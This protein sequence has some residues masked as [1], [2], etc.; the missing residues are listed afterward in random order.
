MSWLPAAGEPASSEFERVFSLRP[1]LYAAW[2]EFAAL[3]WE[4]RL[5]PPALLELVRLRVAQM[6]GVDAARLRRM[7]EA[8]EAGFDESR[9]ASLDA[10]WKSDR[11]GASERACLRLAEQFVLDAKAISSEEVAPVRAQLGDAGTVAFV[12]ALALFDGFTRFQKMLG[13]AKLAGVT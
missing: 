3:F 11:F 13:I 7:S 5:V 6:H 12:E 8:T 10:W 9:V 1:N 2:Q 4:K